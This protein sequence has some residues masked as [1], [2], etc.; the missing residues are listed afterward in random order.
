[1]SSVTEKTKKSVLMK[2]KRLD[3]EIKSKNLEFRQ[4]K[5]DDDNLMI[6]V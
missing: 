4:A 2:I 5:I 3:D 6:R 1:M